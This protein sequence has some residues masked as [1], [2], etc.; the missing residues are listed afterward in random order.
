LYLQHNARFFLNL[1]AEQ[2]GKRLATNALPF[3]IFV[4]P[5]AVEKYGEEEEGEG[6]DRLP[7]TSCRSMA[8]EQR[9]TGSACTIRRSLGSLGR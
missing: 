4:Y 6:E 9:P 2:E 1:V 8:R 7:D 3:A 5:W